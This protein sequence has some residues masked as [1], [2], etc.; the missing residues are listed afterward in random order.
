MVRPVPTGPPAGAPWRRHCRPRSGAAAPGVRPRP[1]TSPDTA[2]ASPSAACGAAGLHRHARPSP[3]RRHPRP[4]G[5]GS[6]PA[7]G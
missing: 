5:H 7:T 2:P 6:S 3:G 1:G 4:P